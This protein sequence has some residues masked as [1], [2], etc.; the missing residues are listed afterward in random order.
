MPSIV[1]GGAFI[2]LIPTAPAAS[3]SPSSFVVTANTFFLS[4]YL[5]VR[6]VN[7]VLIGISITALPAPPAAADS[8]FAGSAD[9][10]VADLPGLVTDVNAIISTFSLPCSSITALPTTPSRGGDPVNF[11]GRAAAEVAALPTLRTQLNAFITALLAYN[12]N[13]TRFDATGVHWDS[14]THTWDAG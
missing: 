8:G 9:T 6:E 7:S 3:E 4:L 1:N 12:P 5:M 2:P 11:P 13:S 10:F 14:T